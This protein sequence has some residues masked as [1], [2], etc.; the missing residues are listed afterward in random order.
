MSGHTRKDKPDMVG[1]YFEE[2]W[3]DIYLRKNLFF[4]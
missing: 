1:M 2:S 3:S 4:I